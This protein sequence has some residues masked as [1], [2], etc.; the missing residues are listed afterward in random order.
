MSFCVKIEVEQVC[1]YV[2][3]RKKGS[4]YS[5]NL[6]VGSVVLGDRVLG[7]LFIDKEG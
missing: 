2:V 7:F 1:V 4:Q 3:R 6:E 5:G